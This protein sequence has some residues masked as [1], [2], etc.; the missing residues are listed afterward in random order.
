MVLHVEKGMWDDDDDRTIY[1]ELRAMIQ[2]TP[3]LN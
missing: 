3:D 1:T 2:D